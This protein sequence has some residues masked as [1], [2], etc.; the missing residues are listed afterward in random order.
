MGR[1]GADCRG[2]PR[3]GRGAD[4]RA[5]PDQGAKEAARAARVRS[6]VGVLAAQVRRRMNNELNF[7]PNS[8]RLVLGWID[9]D[10]CK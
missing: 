10:F 7:P 6:A 1:G 4:S 2:V 9:A 8:E 3:F 5:R